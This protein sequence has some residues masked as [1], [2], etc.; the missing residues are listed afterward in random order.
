M[1]DGLLRAVKD[2]Y[3]LRVGQIRKQPLPEA[4]IWLFRAV[5]PKDFPRG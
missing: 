2:V 1:K 3:S 4:V 5:E